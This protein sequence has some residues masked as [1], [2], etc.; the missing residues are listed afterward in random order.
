MVSINFH[1]GFHCIVSF[2][3]LGMGSIKDLQQVLQNVFE[4]N[5]CC[6]GLLNK[7]FP[8]FS[9]CTIISFCSI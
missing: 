2:L 3:K 1:G 7:V 6:V 9:P 4:V 5:E 8:S